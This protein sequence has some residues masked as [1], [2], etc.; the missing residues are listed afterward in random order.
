MGQL[1][2]YCNYKIFNYFWAVIMIIM[3]T[4]VLY[5]RYEELS[6]PIPCSQGIKNESCQKKPISIL[7]WDLP[8]IRRYQTKGYSEED[9]TKTLWYYKLLK[10]DL[11]LPG[12]AWVTWNIIQFVANYR[13]L[14]CKESTVNSSYILL[15]IN[16][17]CLWV[18]IVVCRQNQSP[19]KV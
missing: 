13:F 2:L 7:D 17:V 12:Q 18:E 9:L 5:T 3:S 4:N 6:H 15:N 8:Y 14:A 11:P 19:H 16:C 10:F 1:L